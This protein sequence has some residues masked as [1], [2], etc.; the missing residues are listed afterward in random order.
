[1]KL[2]LVVARGSRQGSVVPITT[3]RFLIGR[4][5]ECHL[6]ANSARISQHHCA[7]LI[8]GSEVF[9][10]DLDSSNGT[11]VN[12]ERV[13][14]ERKV[15]HQDLLEIG[16]LAFFVHMETDVADSAAAFTPNRPASDADAA[17]VLL[18]DSHPAILGLADDSQCDSTFMDHPVAA[19]P[20]PESSAPP[21]AESPSGDNPE[22]AKKILEKYER[23]VKRKYNPTD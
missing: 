14:G 13:E 3:R 7:L 19:A 1:M 2:T 17:E 18:Q 23:A 4:H 6:K 5:K 20:P 16:P 9:V 10:R 22:L 12:Q 15:G 11:Y 8:R 21:P